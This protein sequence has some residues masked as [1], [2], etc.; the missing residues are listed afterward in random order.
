MVLHNIQS[1]SVSSELCVQ[2][3]LGG[4][5]T[6]DAFVAETPQEFAYDADGNLTGDGLWLYEW[7]AWEG[8]RIG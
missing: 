5:T 4:L 1:L 2:E 6:W 8:G 3:V 7:D